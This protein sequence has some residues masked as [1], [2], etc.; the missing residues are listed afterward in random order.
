MANFSFSSNIKNIQNQ[1]VA[2]SIRDTSNFE[3]LKSEESIKTVIKSY[4]DRFK[5]VEG[6]LTEIANYVAKSKE[7]IKT[8][9]F[10]NLFESVYFDLQVLYSDLELV[11]N[12]LALNLQRNKNYFSV[13]KKRLTDLWSRLNVTR[14][15]SFDNDPTDEC[16]FEPINTQL[17]FLNIQNVQL[18]KKNGYLHLQPI[19]KSVQNESFKIKSITSQLQPADNSDGGVSHTT[20]ILNTFSD[21]YANGSRDML[22]NGLYKE[23][24]ICSDIPDMIINVTSN[25]QPL[26]RNYHG[27]V[28]IVDIEFNYPVEINKIDF[29]LFGDFVT[30]IDMVFYKTE[31]QDEWKLIT[32]TQEDLLDEADSRGL[33]IEQLAH[34]KGF[35]TISFYN[36][37]KVN[38]KFLRVILNQENYVFVENKAIKET[39]IDER[40]YEDLSERRYEL[41]KFGSSLDDAL[42]TP[43]SDENTSLYSQIM[44]IVETNK[45]IEDILWKIVKL[46]NPEVKIQS[47]DFARSLLFELGTWSIEPVLEKY[48][49]QIGSF[50]TIDYKLQDKSLI[51]VSLATA[52]ETPLYTTCNWYLNLNN[53]NIPIIENNKNWRKEPANIIDFS[54]IGLFG[55][56]PGIFVNLDFPVDPALS[57]NIEIFLEG[58]RL[59]L[60]ESK[61]AF[62]N[63]KLIYINNITARNINL[64]IRY[65]AAIHSSV[66]VYTLSKPQLDLN[67]CSVVSSRKETLQSL[68][69]NSIDLRDKYTVTC[70]TASYE[71]SKIW[72]GTNFNSVIFI[73]NQIS[74]SLSYPVYEVFK[75]SITYGSSKISA[76]LT[77][78]QNY[79]T[80]AT[81]IYDFSPKSF[82]SP[83]MPQ[84]VVSR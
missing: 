7:I 25:T 81:C 69:N 33:N 72:F 64:V 54:N 5:S 1:L 23:Q 12:V 82:N 84:I 56:W 48:T 29:D 80:G 3:L 50:D 17:N 45:N 4:I 44:G 70:T 34:K 42:S 28:S 6:R 20:N 77:D 53:R 37:N 68:I 66:L 71:E 75:N 62:L 26:Y 83:N 38:I 58:E 46:I 31:S 52:Q 41:V 27:I 79:I 57:D 21:N 9:D 65:P 8:K 16:Y 18:D 24:A 67:T 60:V 59:D 32:K 11:D 49:N 61:L 47:V 15:N 14:L 73:D 10:N 2:Q 13:I 22:M 78:I 19:E 51:S 40:I 63:S 76:E 55:D 39:S 74:I 35:D 36:I 43:V 30:L